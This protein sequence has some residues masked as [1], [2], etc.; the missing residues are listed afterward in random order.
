MVPRLPLPLGMVDTI[1][2]LTVLVVMALALVNG[3][4]A[5][6][7]IVR[8]ARHLAGRSPHGGLAFWLPAFGSMRDARIWLGQWRALFD[9]HDPE[10]VKIRVD[11]RLVVGR[12]V[13]L[14]LLSQT[15]AIALN[16]LAPSLI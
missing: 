10:L 1:I 9:S 2:R 7:V 6:L 3:V 11:A 12:H 16:A 5:A 4:Q 8:F 13:H 15:W 14:A